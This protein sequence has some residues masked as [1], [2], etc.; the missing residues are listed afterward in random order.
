MAE[1]RCKNEDTVKLFRHFS[2]IPEDMASGGVLNFSY[3]SHFL[4]WINS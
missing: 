3:D 4:V 1:D 2:K